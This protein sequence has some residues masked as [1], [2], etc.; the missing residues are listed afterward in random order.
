M[1]RHASLQI[2]A[3]IKAEF[4]DIRASAHQHIRPSADVD[5]A[6]RLIDQHVP[7]RI[8]ARAEVLR[9]SLL[10][11]LMEDALESLS[12]ATVGDRNQFYALDIRARMEETFRI[13]R[14]SLHYS[15]DPRQRDG[16]AAASAT[17]ITGGMIAGLV[18]TGMLSRVAVGMATVGVAVAA[19]KGVHRARTS[20]ARKSLQA[21]LSRYLDQ[22][23]ARV[24]VWLDDVRLSFEQAFDEYAS[25]LKPASGVL[26]G[27]GS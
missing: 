4:I 13:E 5:H 26:D 7:A 12:S 10:N 3:N 11:Y 21:D 23:E 6:R 18:L 19:Y 1:N 8:V 22:S 17:V 2:G 14:Q 15:I 20:A 24:A 27:G 25:T 16:L 9:D